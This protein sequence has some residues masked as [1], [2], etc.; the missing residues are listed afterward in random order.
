MDIRRWLARD[1][2]PARIGRS[3]VLIVRLTLAALAAYGVEAD[4][5]FFSVSV[6][7]RVTALV[8]R[9]VA[10]SCSSNLLGRG[11]VNDNGE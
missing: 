11:P 6:P 3:F 1:G 7:D 10:T 9:V 5:L 4:T 8:E 2:V